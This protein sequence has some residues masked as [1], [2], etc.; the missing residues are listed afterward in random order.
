MLVLYF[1]DGLIHM[2]SAQ[3]RWRRKVMG[4]S[5]RKWNKMEWS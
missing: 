4:E 1:I 5:H 3:R 2:P